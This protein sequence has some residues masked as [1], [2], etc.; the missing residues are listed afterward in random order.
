MNKL[1]LIALSLGSFAFVEASEH[2]SAAQKSSFE[3][4][5]EW[6]DKQ[7]GVINGSNAAECK[8]AAIVAVP[9]RNTTN[10]MPKSTNPTALVSAVFQRGEQDIFCSPLNLDYLRATMNPTYYAAVIEAFVKE[11]AKKSK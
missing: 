1:F 9:A 8:Q 4:Q 6:H 10:S 3:E 11:R 5:I 2:Y 7:H